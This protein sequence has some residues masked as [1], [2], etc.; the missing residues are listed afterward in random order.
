MISIDEAKNI[1]Q[2]HQPG[3]RIVRRSLEESLGLFLAEDLFAPEP[4]PRFDNSAMDGYAVALPAGGNR[5]VPMTLPVVGESK[6][7]VPYPGVM[8]PGTTIKISTGAIVPEGADLVVPVEYTD[9]TDDEVTLLDLGSNGEH[10]RKRGEE[11]REG[12]IL[13]PAQTQL[14]PPVLAWS[15]AFGI[16]EILVFEPP[17]V[18]VLTT[19]HEL[20]DYT[21]EPEP[22]QIRNSNQVYLEQLLLSMGVE[23]VMSVKVPDSFDETVSAIRDA[24]ELADIILISG[25][26]SVGP[27]DH[28]KAAAEELGFERHFWKVLQKPGKPLYFASKDDTLLFGLPGNPVSTA[29]STLVYVYPVLQKMLGALESD[30]PNLKMK[31]SESL[32]GLMSDRARFLLV[33]IREENGASRLTQHPNQRSHMLSGVTESDGFVIVPPETDNL[34]EGSEVLVHLFPWQAGKLNI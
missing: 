11:I 4:L 16:A 15:A 1:I 17:K 2:E 12:D 33:Q 7:G 21:A 9:S 34:S 26:V 27:H 18:A 19:G 6:A 30:L 14:T 24:A 25:G 20:I 29:M 8:N 10:I 23:K 31:L 5:R 3:P 32:T 13:M 28:V 22:G